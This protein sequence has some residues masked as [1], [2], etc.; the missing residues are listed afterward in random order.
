M[1]S[2]RYSCSAT[3]GLRASASRRRCP[4]FHSWRACSTAVA[5]MR[6]HTLAPAAATRDVHAAP[7]GPER[8]ELRPDPVA[9]LVAGLCEREGEMRG[10]PLQPLWRSRPAD[11]EIERAAAVGADAIARELLSDL[12]LS[13]GR[14][15][16]AG[17]ERRV[18][19]GLVAP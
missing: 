9:E 1:S 16:E 15:P 3:P 13:L 2:W 7:V 12:P 5:A 8:F 10:Q 18:G 14:A 4:S 17:S 6:P 19:G 11:A